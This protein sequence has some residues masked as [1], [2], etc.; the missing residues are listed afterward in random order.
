MENNFNLIYEQRLNS[1]KPAVPSD[2]ILT[3]FLMRTGLAELP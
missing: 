2:R 1:G 3:L